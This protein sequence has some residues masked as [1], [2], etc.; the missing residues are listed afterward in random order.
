MKK[1][2]KRSPRLHRLGFIKGGNCD[3]M[4]VARSKREE[5][6]LRAV[7]MLINQEKRCLESVGDNKFIVKN[8]PKWDWKKYWQLWGGDSEIGVHRFMDDII[9]QLIKTKMEVTIE[10]LHKFAKQIS[11][12]EFTFGTIE[13]GNPLAILEGKV[14]CGYGPPHADHIYR[15]R[16]GK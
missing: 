11:S 4:H 8:Y 12:F 16:F 1:I 6:A 3:R 5:G 13:P 15:K 2:R 7:E 10:L 14:K 9:P